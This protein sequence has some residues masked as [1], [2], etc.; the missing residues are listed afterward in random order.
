M[1]RHE[2]AG[3]TLR[4]LRES[5]AI[6]E[7]DHFVY[8]SGEHGSGWIDKDAI[9]PHTTRTAALC[10]LLAAA[11]RPLNAEVVCGPATGGLI[12]AQWT[13]HSLGALAVFGEHDRPAGGALVGSFLLRRG[14]DRLVAGRRVV[15]V[16]D[17][18][19]TGLSVRQMAAAVRSAGGEVVGVAA[20]VTRGNADA[21]A[22]GVEPFITL[23]EYDIPSWPA[24]GCPLCRQGVPVNTR[25]AHGKEFLAAQAT[26]G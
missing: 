6:L 9:Y 10:R 5:H 12:I 7:D 8:D 4:I 22:I 19:S 16:D 21:D 14:Y 3:E 23:L 15:V 2:T 20:L 11:V 25:Y 17:V 13:A 18:V 26:H 24:A 1:A